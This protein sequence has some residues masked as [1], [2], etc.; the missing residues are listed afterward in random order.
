MRVEGRT[1]DQ[2]SGL[3]LYLLTN[4]QLG[5]EARLA[6]RDVEVTGLVGW[7]VGWFVVL[8]GNPSVE[9][10]SSEEEEEDGVRSQD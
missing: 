4:A 9:H 1:L 3:F 10:Q 7:L 5:E 8:A 2:E 6:V